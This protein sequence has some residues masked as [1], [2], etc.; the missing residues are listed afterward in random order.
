MGKFPAVL[1]AGSFDEDLFRLI[2]VF[3]DAKL[4]ER[5]EMVSLDVL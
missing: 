3:A 5:V 2:T 1:W 4:E